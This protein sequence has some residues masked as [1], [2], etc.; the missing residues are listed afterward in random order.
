MTSEKFIKKL[1]TE[2]TSKLETH[3]YIIQ[4]KSM[5]KWCPNCNQKVFTL[6]QPNDHISESRF[7]DY[8][9]VCVKCETTQLLKSNEYS[10]KQDLDSFISDIVTH[11][12]LEISA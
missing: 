7:A 10:N 12:N 9:I 2:L 6:N 8:R 1:Y 4:S 3:N 5:R 11:F